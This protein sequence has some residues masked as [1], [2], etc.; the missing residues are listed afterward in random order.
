MAPK[1]DKTTSDD[2]YGT[3]HQTGWSWNLTR[4][5]RYFQLLTTKIQLL[6]ARNSSIIKRY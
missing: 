5:W 1:V 6:M 4:T 3:L 2:S